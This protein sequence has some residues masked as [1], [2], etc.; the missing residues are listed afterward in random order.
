[1]KKIHLAVIEDNQVVA[2]SLKEFFS[3]IA[4]FELVKS[5][6]SVEDFLEQA[7]KTEKLDILLL[8]INLPGMSGI[9]GIP[10]IMDKY[11]KTDII[12]LTTFDDS[13]SIFQALRAGACSYLSKRSSLMKIKEAIEIVSEGGSFMSPSIARKVIASFNRTKSSAFDEIT[14]RQKQVIDGLIDGLSYQQIADSNFISV[15]TVRDHI[16]KI[17]KKLQVNSRNELVK[18]SMNRKD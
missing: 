18:L 12:M 5:C 14:P 1:M 17:Y 7:D 2:D 9:K 4:P 13:D 3:T 15:E 6:G 11:P 16:K 8:D 10:F